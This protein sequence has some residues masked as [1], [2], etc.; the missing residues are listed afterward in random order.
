MKKTAKK[1]QNG[2]VKPTAEI[3]S[4]IFDMGNVL[5]N[6][7]A[8]RAGRQF[9]K[10]CGVPKTKVWVHFFTS[11]TEKAYTRGEISTKEFFEHAKQV[12][13]LPVAYKDFCHYWNDIFWENHGMEAL[14]KKLKAHYPLYLISN[15]N[16]LH[17]LHIKKKFPNIFR[18]FKKTF[19]S[20][21]VGSR[22]PEPEI[23]R[24]V[25]KK[26]GLRAEETVFVDDM[27]KFVEGAK[28]VGMHAIRFRSK[29]QLVRELKKLNVK[30]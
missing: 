20:H 21:E 26:I 29:D 1:N 13:K 3:K 2:K 10:A 14:L 15:T 24:R 30:V 28:N 5:L 16:E 6:Y 18:H 8:H 7:D 27:P 19:P 9:A 4:V 25:L 12:M 22:K 11:P 17:F 23:Y